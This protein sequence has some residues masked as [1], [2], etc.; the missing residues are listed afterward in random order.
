MG[1]AGT[2]REDRMGLPQPLDRAA[3]WSNLT[4]NYLTG[5]LTAGLYEQVQSYLGDPEFHT[6]VQEF[7]ADEQRHALGLRRHMAE[8]G[9]PLPE[10]LVGLLR[11]TARLAG[12]GVALRGAESFLDTVQ[13][14]EGLEARWYQDLAGRFPEGSPDAQRYEAYRAQIAS[15]HAWLERYQAL[16]AQSAHADEV[17]EFASIVPA[18]AEEVFAF[19]TDTRSLSTLLGVPVDADGPTRFE[20]GD[21]FRLRLGWPPIITTEVHVL[22]MESPHLYVDRKLNP[23]VE[24]WEHQHHFTALG[25]DRTLVSDRLRFRLKGL[26]NMPNALQPS[27]PRLALLLMLWWQHQRLQGVFRR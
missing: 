8:V 1:A 18:P 2:D 9:P 6:R 26:P 11:E 20:A 27:A 22:A 21:R 16:R 19:H 15:H 23:L 24:T 7:L 5:V 3:L 10:P 17:I 14:L 25:P 12:V 4:L 13:R